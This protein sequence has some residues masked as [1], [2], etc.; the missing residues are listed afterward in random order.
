[1][2]A[3]LL[4]IHH[5]I[6]QRHLVPTASGIQGLKISS[7]DILVV[8]PKDQSGACKRHNKGSG[9]DVMLGHLLL[10][11]CHQIPNP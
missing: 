3:A 11:S 10:E 6:K 2:V 8:F 5:D 9:Y 7:Q 4:K 1:M